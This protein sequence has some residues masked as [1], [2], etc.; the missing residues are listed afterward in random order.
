MV[1]MM[2]ASVIRRIYSILFSS[3]TADKIL[4]NIPSIVHYHCD[5]EFI[6]KFEEIIIIGDIH[7]C[8]DEFQL[9]L[10]RIHQ[11]VDNPK[12]ILKICAGDLINK[13]PKSKEVL[14]YFMKNQDDCISVRGNHDQVMINEYI[15]YIKTGDIAEK[16]SWLKELTL[17]GHFEFLRQLPY[18]IRIPKLNI[19][20]VHAGLLPDV[21]L[22][23]Q[24]LVD[25]IEMRNIVENGDNV[26]VATKHN[27]EGV[28]WAS[29]WQGPWHIYFGHDARR[30]LQEHPYATGLDTGVVYG[31]ELTAKFVMG[32][33]KGH[34]VSV[35]ALQ[36][37]NDPN[38]KT[39]K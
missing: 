26:R 6:E 2:L 16:N 38:K 1:K 19:L 28:A 3:R 24:Q 22:E 10:E 11:G 18:T 13:G 17:D 34:L 39:K 8:Y 21:S 27:D 25:M 4:N 20:I 14:E 33:R 9:L 5:D 30:K 7:G 12:K 36:M 37:W 32:P 35:K 23:N 31:N 15:N 29:V